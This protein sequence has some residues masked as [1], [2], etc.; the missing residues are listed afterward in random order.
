M[1]KKS[2]S[3]KKDAE[4]EILEQLILCSKKVGA[5]VNGN[6]VTFSKEALLDFFFFLLKSQS[7]LTEVQQKSEIDGDMLNELPL[8]IFYRA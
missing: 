7:I 3:S 4:T 6:S 2:L 1:T 8:E 5:E